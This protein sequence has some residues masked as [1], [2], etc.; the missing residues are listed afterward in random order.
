MQT[1]VRIRC[2]WQTPPM[3]ANGHVPTNRDPACR[4]TA[5]SRRAVRRSFVQKTSAVALSSE[6]CF[7]LAEAVWSSSRGQAIERCI[8]TQGSQA[9]P[10]AD[11]GSAG[12]AAEGPGS[13]KDLVRDAHAGAV[14][15]QC[16]IHP[17][18]PQLVLEVDDA[19]AE[20]SVQLV[21]HAP[22][23]RDVGETARKEPR[24]S[25][26]P[27]QRAPCRRAST[28]RTCESGCGVRSGSGPDR[29]PGTG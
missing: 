25:L 20:L 2:S 13:L 22:T 10:T 23:Q 3:R 9:G 14:G 6:S 26:L 15:F 27:S 21:I 17:V 5:S 4:C 11:P 19:D 16:S 24:N 28:A 29:Y 1:K 12:F 7:S 8:A 18:R